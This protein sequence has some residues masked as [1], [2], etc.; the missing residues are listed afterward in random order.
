MEYRTQ[1]SILLDHMQAG[2]WQE[3]LKMAA[4]WHDLGGHKTVIERGA[5][6][7]E[8]PEFYKQLGQDPDALVAAGIDA[9]K[10]R[11][12]AGLALVKIQERKVSRP[13]GGDAVKR[14]T[15]RNRKCLN[16]RKC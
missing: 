8:H 2:R 12:S 13:A 4:R 7:I 15:R 3:A 6:A 14:K 11:Y 10:H 1:L 16:M 5:T 9:L